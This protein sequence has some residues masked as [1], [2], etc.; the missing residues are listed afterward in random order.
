MTDNKVGADLDEP[1]VHDYDESENDS[2]IEYSDH[3]HDHDHG[4]DVSEELN[5]NYELPEPDLSDT[6]SNPEEETKSIGTLGRVYYIGLVV[7]LTVPT[8]LRVIFPLMLK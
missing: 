7:I 5:R 8:I 1:L 6:D 4:D 2:V 3:D